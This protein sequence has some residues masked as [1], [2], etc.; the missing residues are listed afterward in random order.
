MV[1]IWLDVAHLDIIVF[2]VLFTVPDKTAVILR[3]VLFVSYFLLLLDFILSIESAK[4]SSLQ[5]SLEEISIKDKS[6]ND[7]Y[8]YECKLYLFI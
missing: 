6:T 8:K 4:E 3:F 5:H 2:N 7:L 1:R